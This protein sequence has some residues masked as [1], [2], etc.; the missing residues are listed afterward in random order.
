MLLRS[1]WIHFRDFDAVGIYLDKFQRYEC[2]WQ[3]FEVG[4]EQWLILITLHVIRNLKDCA[5]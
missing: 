3:V 4:F 5:I 1:L 2:C